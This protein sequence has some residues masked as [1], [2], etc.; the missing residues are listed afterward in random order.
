MTAYKYFNHYGTRVITTRIQR[1]GE[2]T[3]FSLFVSSHLNW[4]RGGG[5]PARSGWWGRGYPSQV[6]MVGGSQGTPWP[7]LDGGWEVPGVPPGQVWMVGGTQGTP[8]Q[9]WMV[10]GTRGTQPGQVWMVGDAWGTPIPPE[11]DGV[12][13][14]PGLDGGWEVLGVPLARSGYAT[15]GWWGYQGYP[16]QPGLDGGGCLGY[17]STTRT[18]WGTPT[19]PPIRQ[20]SIVSTCYTAGGLAFM[21]EDF[22]VFSIVFRPSAWQKFHYYMTN[23]RI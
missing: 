11:L 3:V 23:S 14:C 5:T 15:S 2:G 18:G 21:Q 19:P 20:S 13:P 6:W 16:T 4:G 9:V 22:L 12:S 17:S 8:S 7:G 1:M 10:A